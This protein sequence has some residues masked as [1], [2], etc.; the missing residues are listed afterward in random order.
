MQC[1]QLWSSI[2]LAFCAIAQHRVLI[3]PALVRSR[4]LLLRTFRPIGVKCASRPRDDKSLSTAIWCRVGMFVAALSFPVLL[5]RG[6]GSVKRDDVRSRRWTRKASWLCLWS[7]LSTSSSLESHAPLWRFGSLD[8]QL[9]RTP[10][11]I[12][13]PVS[14]SVRVSQLVSQR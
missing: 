6:S 8:Q 3:L 12:S 13:Q 7:A 14:L 2:V 5:G 1:F 10:G 4:P 11:W 9:R